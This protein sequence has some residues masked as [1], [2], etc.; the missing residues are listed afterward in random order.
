M[1]QI[2]ILRVGIGALTGFSGFLLARRLCTPLTAYTTARIWSTLK[3]FN[4]FQNDRL[5]GYNET[6]NRNLD[7]QNALYLRERI[8][9]FQNIASGIRPFPYQALVESALGGALIEWLARP[10]SPVAFIPVP[11][12]WGA[13]HL[14]VDAGRKAHRAIILQADSIFSV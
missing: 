5:F 8:C 7:A 1:D 2:A 3:R 9:Q 14:I 10:I 11:F 4:Q 12:T 6:A 13:A